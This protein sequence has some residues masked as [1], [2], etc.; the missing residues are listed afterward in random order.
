MPTTLVMCTRTIIVKT[1]YLLQRVF[2]QWRDSAKRSFVLGIWNTA[3]VALI[4]LMSNLGCSAEA[5]AEASTAANAQTKA[6]APEEY[7]PRI[8]KA[9]PS[10]SHWLTP[11]IISAREQALTQPQ[12]LRAD[13]EVKRSELARYQV[14][15][16]WNPELT[17]G[18]NFDENR[19]LST[20]SVDGFGVVITQNATANAAIANTFSTGTTLRLQA[21]SQQTQN[22]SA[23]SLT[24]EYY[25]STVQLI[26]TQALLQ[27][28]SYQANTVDLQN[29]IDQTNL[30]RDTRD[31][32]IEAQLLSLS[33]Q[34]IDLAQ[35][36]I[37]LDLR[38]SHLA[39]TRRYLTF[40]EERSRLGLGRELDAFSLRRDVAADEAAIGVAERAIA[41]IKERLMVDWPNLT[42]PSGSILRQTERPVTPPAI[43]FVGTRSG[44][45][46]LRQINISSRT[47]VV[48]RSNSLDRLDLSG[49]IGKNGTD[50]SLNGSWSEVSNPETYRWALGLSYTHRFGS[51][52]ERVELHR[53]T[54]ALD[55]T[56]LQGQADERTWRT[57][58]LTLRLALDDARS[59]V[60]DLE[61]VYDAYRE[62]YRLTKAQADAGLIAMRDLISVDNQ[63]NAALVQVV[64][65]HLDT[66]RAEVRLR[67]HEDRLLELLPK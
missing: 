30:A 25:N 35:S 11:L 52:A 59:R 8:P 47:L 18:T 37:E 20:S 1:L 44:Q 40:A 16:R 53:A 58:A 63:L 31:E 9:I 29:T 67:A 10:T 27:G 12:V 46:S 4:L 39:L 43:S 5:N 17:L 61:R 23:S 33:E 49:S 65:A 2:H 36:G 32:L 45:N 13:R 41:G 6:E 28:G 60:T 48:A 64:Q 21:V 56:K 24:P 19:Q 54:L 38:R 34:W 55:Q 26:M 7:P 62:E 14:F 3:I 15:A 22:S 51:D 66:L 50:P 42:L 57:Q